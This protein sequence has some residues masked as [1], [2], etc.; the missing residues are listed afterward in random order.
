MEINVQFFENVLTLLQQSIW[1]TKIPLRFTFLFC[2]QCLN[3]GG[4]LRH[5]VPHIE[6]GKRKRNC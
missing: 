6:N 5:I 2:Y 4:D 3:L 1:D